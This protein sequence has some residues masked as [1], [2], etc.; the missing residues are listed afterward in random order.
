MTGEEIRATRARLGLTQAQ[1]GK[2]LGVAKNTIARWERGE[3]RIE[4]PEML[5]LS[6]ERISEI[7]GKMQ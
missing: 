4:R 3:L 7:L 1:L 2:A 5:R 6:L